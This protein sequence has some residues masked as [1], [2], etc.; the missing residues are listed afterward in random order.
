MTLL[1][2]V[3]DERS[4]FIPGN[5]NSNK[6]YQQLRSCWGKKVMMK[7]KSLKFC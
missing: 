1:T 2:V 7:R 3:S 5:R 4:D 6:G